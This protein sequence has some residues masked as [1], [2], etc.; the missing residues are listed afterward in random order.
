M[1]LLEPSLHGQPADLRGIRSMN[2][3]T[4]LAR[5]EIMTTRVLQGE[6]C[7]RVAQDYGLSVTRVQQIV[8]QTLH[9]V[10]CTQAVSEVPLLPLDMLRAY[11][12]REKSL[13]GMAMVTVPPRRP[14][15]LLEELGA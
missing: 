9:H 10:C 2:A 13:R 4:L 8:R 5:N 6:T 12:A 15:M 14:P 3:S 7:R 11:Y 1:P